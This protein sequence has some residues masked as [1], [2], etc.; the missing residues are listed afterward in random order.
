MKLVKFFKRLY[1]I[2]FH[3]TRSLCYFKNVEINGQ[4]IIEAPD[5]TCRRC[6]EMK[7]ANV[8]TLVNC[9]ISGA[10]GE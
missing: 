2:I 3:H 9:T 5:R 1:C 10:D 6:G 8:L 7:H 4:L